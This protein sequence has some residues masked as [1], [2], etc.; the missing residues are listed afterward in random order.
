MV[1]IVDQGVVVVDEEAEDID[2]LHHLE[3]AMGLGVIQYY[4]TLE[5]MVTDHNYSQIVVDT[6]VH[7][8]VVDCN[9]MMEVATVS[10]VV[11][12]QI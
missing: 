7:P 4:M 1:D 9:T 12:M 6:L 8:L 11:D 2:Q 10:L 5:H 3:V